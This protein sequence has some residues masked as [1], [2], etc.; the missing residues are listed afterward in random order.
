ML[1]VIGCRTSGKVSGKIHY[2]KYE[3]NKEV[4]KQYASY[5]LQADRLLVNLTVRETITYAAYLRLPGR[6]TQTEIEAKVR[7]SL[8]LTVFM[9]K[10]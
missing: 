9:S 2:N 8:H 3:C 1:D 6:A 7:V 10:G 5:V 4:I